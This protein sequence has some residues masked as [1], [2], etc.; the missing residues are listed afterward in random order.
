MR[1]LIFSLLLALPAFADPF[2]P[3]VRFT[4]NSASRAEVA[5][6]ATGP[7]AVWLEASGAVR[8]NGH[9]VTDAAVE[10]GVA[11][12]GES[13]LVAWTQADGSVL[14]MR[15][16]ADGTAGGIAR[17]IGSNAS[18][19]VAVAAAAA[20]N[21]YLV[22]WTGSLGEIYAALVSGH[23]VPV[24][25]AMPVTT[26]SSSTIA[27]VAAAASTDGF[28]I[29]WHDLPARKVFATTLDVGGLPVSMTPLLLSENGGFPDVASDGNVFFTAWGIGTI[30]ART[31]TVDRELGRVRNVTAGSAPRIAWDG[32]AYGM[33]F[34]RPVSPRPGF[35]FPVLMTIRV[36]VHG[37]IVEYLSLAN[38]LLP[39]AWDVDAVPGRVDLIMGAGGVA[40]ESAIVREPRLRERVRMVRH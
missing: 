34:V 26:Q 18:G 9:L 4:E 14:V 7:L 8:A 35:S 17:K 16:R 39:G 28:A 12:A 2:G 19:E 3:P 5:S 31:L 33:A 36:T 6:M 20:E 29:V 21:R 40:V 22:A 38:Q 13:A 27:E 11:S 25:P 37:T 10:L 32:F 30:Y 23:G 15:R 24:M 1:L